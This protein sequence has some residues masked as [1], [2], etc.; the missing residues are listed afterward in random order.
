MIG[1]LLMATKG[2]SA[3]PSHTPRKL[4]DRGG[5]RAFDRCGRWPNSGIVCA[6]LGSL[7]HNRHRDLSLSKLAVAS[8][9]NPVYYGGPCTR[10][11]RSQPLFLL[12]GRKVRH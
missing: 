1:E 7:F 11:T 3:D 8:Q 12:F 5:N 9:E 6:R 4:K 10:Y 2:S